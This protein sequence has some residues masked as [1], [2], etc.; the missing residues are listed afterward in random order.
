MHPKAAERW[1]FA[2]DSAPGHLIEQ[3]QERTVLSNWANDLRETFRTIGQAAEAP[4][5]DI[6]ILMN[7]SLPSV[8]AGYI[9]VSG[10]M[11]DHL[12]HQ[13]ERISRTVLGAVRSGSGKHRVRTLAWLCSSNIEA[14]SERQVDPVSPKRAA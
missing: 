14:A 2:A 6:H 5:L 9:T 4:P 13:Q 10:L 8:N 1:I 7:H 12:R 11:D 3:K